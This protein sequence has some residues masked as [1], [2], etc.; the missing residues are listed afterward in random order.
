M[1]KKHSPRYKKLHSKFGGFHDLASFR[2]ETGLT[3]NDISD[4]DAQQVI[5]EDLKEQQRIA[6]KKLR[7]TELQAKNIIIRP[8]EYTPI[9]KKSTENK[10]Y[11]IDNSNLI[12]KIKKE[13]RDYPWDKNK[14]DYEIAR[15]LEKQKLR[16]ELEEE[17]LADKKW[18]DADELFKKHYKLLAK[19][20]TK[21]AAKRSPKRSTKRSIKSAAK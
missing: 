18:K 11:Y 15:Y 1:S 3:V 4:V 13:L 21:S 5:L 16:K 14:Q 20:S 2:A 8:T 7:D 9:E 6:E 19:R 10:F 12:D 17:L